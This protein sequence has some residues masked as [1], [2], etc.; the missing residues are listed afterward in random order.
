M[1]G[2]IYERSSTGERENNEYDGLRFITTQ[3]HNL[4][5]ATALLFAGQC[6]NQMNQMKLIHGELDR[7]CGQWIIM[8]AVSDYLLARIVPQ[9]FHAGVE[10]DRGGAVEQQNAA[11]HQLHGRVFRKQLELVKL[12]SCWGEHGGVSTL[13]ALG[14]VDVLCL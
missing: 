6:L 11:L 8:I 13:H 2:Q 12:Q 4:I 9:E 5:E 10:L 14:D 7:S 1:S 3:Q